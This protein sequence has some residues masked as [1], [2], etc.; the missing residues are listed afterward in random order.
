MPTYKVPQKIRNIAAKAIEYNLSLPR[1]KRAAMK[2][3][4]NKTVFGTGMK[5]ARKLVRDDVDEKQLILM[6]AWFARHGASEKEKEARRDKTS[7]ASIAWALWGGTQ[8]RR[9]VEGTLRD[10]ERKRKKKKK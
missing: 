8:G 1:S 10:I 2:K 9:W 7:K 5:T 6:R 4:G 3:E